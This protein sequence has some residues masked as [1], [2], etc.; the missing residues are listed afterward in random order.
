MPCMKKRRI[1][2]DSHHAIARPFSVFESRTGAI[3]CNHT[4]DVDGVSV[5][6]GR[7][8]RFVNDLDS[9]TFEYRK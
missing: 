3:E 1:H 4:T 2:T 8:V 9:L 7:G 6:F 5:L